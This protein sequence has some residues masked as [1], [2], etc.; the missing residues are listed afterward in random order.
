LRGETS[1]AREVGGLGGW[2]HRGGGASIGAATNDVVGELAQLEI[3]PQIPHL[4][5]QIADAALEPTNVLWVT[6]RSSDR[7]R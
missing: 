2:G 5:L 6:R 1:G 7:L 4:L 3:R